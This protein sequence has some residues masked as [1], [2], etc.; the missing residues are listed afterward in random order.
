MA[1]PN[2]TKLLIMVG[3]ILALFLEAM[4]QTVV[5]TALPRIVADFQGIALIGWVTTGY[6]LASTALIPIYGKL[7]DSFGRRT[8]L[9]WSISIFLLGSLLCGFSQG[10]L[11]LV[12]FRV[13]QGVGAAGLAS[14]AF[15][16]PA[17]LYPPAERAAA[18]G[19]IGMAFGLA[20]VIGPFIGGYLTD[21]LSWH[22]VFFVNLPV[23]LVALSFILLR[24]PRLAQGRREPIDWWGTLLLLLSVVPILL[25]LSLDRATYGWGSPVTIGLLAFGL[26]ALVGLI[27]VERRVASPIIPLALF[28]NRT[29]VIAALVSALMGIA[30]LS[31]ILFLSLFLVNVVGISAT[32]AGATL[33]PLTLALI[34]SAIGSGVIVQRIGRYKA[35]MLIGVALMSVGFALIATL[36][37]GT[38][39]AD[40]IWRVAIIGLGAGAI[41]PLLQLAVQ[42]VAAQDQVGSAT[43]GLQFFQQIGGV[44][45]SAVASAVLVALITAR[46]QLELAPLVDSLSPELRAA[47]SVERLR[48]GLGGAQGTGGIDLAT[49]PDAVRAAVQT[50]YASSI[51][52]IYW[53]S[54]ACLLVALALL[55]FLPELPLRKGVEPGP[56]H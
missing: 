25:G 1:L 4:D 6:L 21:T 53:A 3:V 17:D 44:V 45:G 22:W 41:I 46:L 15:A 29:F 56:Q 35:I 28:R 37:V 42:N 10:M 18:T 24:M 51:S 20:S 13:I 49:L 34:V 38:T 19:M 48:N 2:R 55:A 31:A 39:Q 7:S 52:T 50:A 27:A 23:G 11:Q 36:G 54:L 9:L 47:L 14:S 26:A 30:F 40:V 43:A 8:I 32:A 12:L 5:A 16:I 33:I